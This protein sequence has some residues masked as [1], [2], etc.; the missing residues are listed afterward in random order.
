MMKTLFIKSSLLLLACLTWGV[1][2]SLAQKTAKVDYGNT[3]RYAK[4][5]AE[6][7]APQKGEKR[8]VFLGNSITE[9]WANTHPDFFK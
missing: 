4:S 1:T 2:T 8:V 6:L 5:N 9:G 7:P 3:P